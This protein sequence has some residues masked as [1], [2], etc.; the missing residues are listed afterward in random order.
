MLADILLLLFLIEKWDG[1]DKGSLLVD[2]H[3]HSGLAM[4]GFRTVDPHWFCVVDEDG[5]GWDGHV[6]GGDG[7][8]AGE[9]AGYVGAV[10][11]DRLAGV[12]EVGLRDGVVL[13]HELELY[14]VTLGSGD[15]VG[16]VGEGTVGVAHRY[17]MNHY[18]AG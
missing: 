17:D 4:L 13:G 12:V 14:H 5:V 7:H 8:E 18:L 6:C 10:H 1:K 3:G 9:D 2:D 15:V 11:A 16:A